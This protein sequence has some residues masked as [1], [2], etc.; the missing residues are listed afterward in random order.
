[1]KYLKWAGLALLA[2]VA[3][4]LLEHKDEATKT[5]IFVG[6]GILYSL[7][8]LAELIQSNHSATVRMFEHLNSK[9]SPE[10]YDEDAKR[11]N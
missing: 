11:I 4:G 6:F 9:V 1:M 5:I 8:H 10:P 7:W 2:L 3:Y